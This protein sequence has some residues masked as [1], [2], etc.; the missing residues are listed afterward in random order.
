MRIIHS[1]SVD[2]RAG[3]PALSTWLT[4][5]GLRSNGT[6]VEVICPPII[7]QE[8]II[9]PDVRPVF[10]NPPRLGRLSYIPNMSLSLEA[11]GDADLY[12]IQ[13]IWM[14]HGWQVSRYA[15]KHRKP[16][17]VTLRGMLYPQ[18]LAHNP[19][20]KKTSLWLYQKKVLQ[21][22]AAIQCTCA[23]EAEHY[24]HLGFRNPVAII[25]NPIETSPIID[26]AIPDKPSVTFGYLGRFHPRKRIERLIYCFAQNRSLLD[27]ARLVLIGGGDQEYEQFLKAEVERLKLNNVSF[28]GFL[29]GE[30]KDDAVHNLSCLVVPSDFENFGNIITESLV[31]GVP[32][33]AS[34]GTPWQSLVENGCGYWIPNDQQSINKAMLEFY[35]L[36]AG[37]RLAMAVNGRRFVKENFSVDVLGTKMQQLYHWILSGGEKPGF[38]ST[39]YTTRS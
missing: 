15:I 25:P 5:K 28:T 3:G 36:S 13:G 16:Y 18:A 14:F 32:V 22:A 39:V 12:H 17:V 1:G 10:C 31:H 30:A 34:E 37:Q 2:V 33:I 19:L 4:I 11:I 38:V 9:S 7:P 6:D 35:N 27:N 21:Q 24:R 29:T 20:V 23:E 8:K 26:L